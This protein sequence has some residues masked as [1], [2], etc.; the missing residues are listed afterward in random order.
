LVD[1]DWRAHSSLQKMEIGRR[2]Q[3][4]SW[5]RAAGKRMCAWLPRPRQPGR[6]Q[7]CRRGAGGINPFLHRDHECKKRQR[8]FARSSLTTFS[9][10]R[11]QKHTQQQRKRNGNNATRRRRR[12]TFLARPPASFEARASQQG[13]CR[14]RPAGHAENGS[15]RQGSHRTRRYSLHLQ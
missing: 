6:Q 5:Q 3:A 11:A 15:T 7:D 1:L 13:I 14:G 9:P 10:P 4:C 2:Q 8:P 12:V